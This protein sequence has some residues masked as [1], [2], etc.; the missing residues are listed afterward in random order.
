MSRDRRETVRIFRDRLQEAMKAA[1]TNRSRLAAEAGIDRSTLSQLLSAE[2]DRLPRADTVAA[3]A[4]VLQVSLDWL[5]GLTQQQ[6]LG[7]EILRESV[8]VALSGPSAPSDENLRRWHAEAAGYKIRYVPASLPDLMKTEAVLRFEYAGYAAKR[9]SEAIADASSKLAYTRTPDADFE[10]CCSRQAFE[11]FAEGAGV[12][13]ELS[14]A[15]RREQLLHAAT[16]TDELYPRLRLF[17]YDGRTHFAVPYTVF[18]PKR[19]AL[20]LGEMYFVFNTTG[21]IRQLTEHFDRLIRAAVV[22]AHEA[23][24]FLRGLA[25]RVTGR[26]RLA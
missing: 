15:D 19:A 12:W 24:V 22:Q 2:T 25:D 3:V 1:G 14:A 13:R 16:L 18:G 23:P 4:S 10:I 9:P 6:K 26:G 21:H 5:M 7:A 17:L 20:F 8:Q 11:T